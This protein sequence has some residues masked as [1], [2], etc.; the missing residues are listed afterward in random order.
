M[1][2][3][4]VCQLLRLTGFR[5]AD[6][7]F[8]R[9]IHRP[10]REFPLHLRRTRGDDLVFQRYIGEMFADFVEIIRS[11]SVLLP[12][13]GL[14]LPTIAG[15]VSLIDGEISGASRFQ[16]LR[17]LKNDVVTRGGFPDHIQHIVAGNGINA[18]ALHRFEDFPVALRGAVHRVKHKVRH[19]A[20]SK[21]AGALVK[22]S[23]AEIEVDCSRFKINFTESRRNLPQR[24]FPAGKFLSN[25]IRQILRDGKMRRIVGKT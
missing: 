3:H 13:V 8:K 25:C 20:F 14:R 10:E 2:G 4:Q 18:A 9:R 7:I 17:R 15:A 1:L 22:F 12:G 21:V 24:G 6:G 11:L 16:R 23:A 5:K 19:P